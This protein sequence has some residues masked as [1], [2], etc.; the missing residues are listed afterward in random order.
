MRRSL[1]LLALAALLGCASAP[2]ELPA[3]PDF[4]VEKVAERTLDALP[5]GP[6]Y[7]R[8]EAFSSL[9]KAQAAASDASLA[10]AV[11][12]RFWLVTLGAQGDATP[13]GE[14]VAEIGPVPRVS[15]RRYML[16][17]NHAHAP[18][19]AATSVHTHPGS[20][21]FYV[22]SG[23]LSQRTPHGIA[24]VNAGQ[25][26]NGH[27]PGIVMQLQSTGR[28]SLDQ[29]VLFVLDADRPFSSPAQFQR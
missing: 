4:V 10:A 27:A 19:G 24:R 25:A 11:S 28:E 15:A 14:R 13:G 22:L 2:A 1:A 6:L 17:I 18:P 9:E 3:S 21:A 23:Q 26:M 20:E 29:L 8:V 5:E 12:G 16:R 7:W